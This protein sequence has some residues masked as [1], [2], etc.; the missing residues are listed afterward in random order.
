MAQQANMATVFALYLEREVRAARLSQAKFA[1]EVLEVSPTTLSQWMRGT[2]RLA[3]MDIVFHK[4]HLPTKKDPSPEVRG[5]SIMAQC[6]EDIALRGAY[7]EAMRADRESVT[8]EAP[9]GGAF[10]SKDRGQISAASEKRRAA[11]DAEK[12]K[13]KKP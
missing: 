6:A 5:L 10:V 3:S 13:P 4:L 11:R 9:I 7:P 8:K 12:K 1:R 2:V